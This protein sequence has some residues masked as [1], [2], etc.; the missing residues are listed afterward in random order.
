MRMSAET[1]PGSLDS[2]MFRTEVKQFFE[3]IADPAQS[4]EELERAYCRIVM[5]A[6]MLDPNDAGFAVAGVSL[7]AALCAWL[8]AEPFQAHGDGSMTT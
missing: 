4:K 3:A 7:K 5:H 2:N 1:P 6:A 8:D